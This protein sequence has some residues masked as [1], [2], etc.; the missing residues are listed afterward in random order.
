MPA[1]TTGLGN[2]KINRSL[3]SE[4]GRFYRK[5]FPRARGPENDLLPVTACGY[6][7]AVWIPLFLKDKFSLLFGFFE[8]YAEYETLCSASAMLRLE[9]A[10]K[11]AIL[12]TVAMKFPRKTSASSGVSIS[13]PLCDQSIFRTTIIPLHLMVFVFP[14]ALGAG[15]GVE[16]TCLRFFSPRRKKILFL[17][18]IKSAI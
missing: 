15:S 13:G 3:K 2:E 12:R 10:C 18:Q 1:R 17:C 9:G 6:G 7:V 11:S 4:P 8:V 16:K 5:G 14:P